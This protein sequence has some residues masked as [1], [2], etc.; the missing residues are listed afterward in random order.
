[1]VKIRHY[2]KPQNVGGNPKRH[3]NRKLKQWTE[4][5]TDNDLT[6]IG[7]T[8]WRQHKPTASCFNF[9]PTAQKNLKFIA[10]PHWHICL[11]PPTAQANAG[12][13]SKECLSRIKFCVGG[14]DSSP[15]SLTAYSLSRCA[16]FYRIDN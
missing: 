12:A 16:I 8:T 6:N 2:A 11:C 3:D 13:K 14:Q 15:Q 5:Q 10:S 4:I 9:F 7:Q 1:V